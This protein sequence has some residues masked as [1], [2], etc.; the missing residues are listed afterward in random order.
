MKSEWIW[1]REGMTTEDSALA[2]VLW[3]KETHP[4]Y[5]HR[6]LGAYMGRGEEE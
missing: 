6:L 2:F 1:M 4:H 5:Y 3:V